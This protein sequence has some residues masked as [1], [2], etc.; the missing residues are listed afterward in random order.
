MFFLL[1]LIA[2]INCA[3]IPLFQRLDFT[4]VNSHKIYGNIYTDTVGT[5]NAGVL[6]G[7][8][9]V[10]IDPINKRYFLWY[11]LLFPTTPTPTLVQSFTWI[12][13]DA[14]YSNGSFSHPGCL[15][16]HG[17][18]W[19]T[20]VNSYNQNAYAQPD[21]TQPGYSTYAGLLKDYGSCQYWQMS[22]I[23]LKDN[24]F[25]QLTL[26]GN[27]I[28]QSPNGPFCY[29]TKNFIIFNR[30]TLEA[31]EDDDFILPSDCTANS[32]DYC[33]FNPACI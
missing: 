23:Q 32:D 9:S 19:T 33:T 11:N 16:A 17:F 7:P 1:S 30:N 10:S 18:N 13:N 12:L 24:Y 15:N 26:T 5:F 4:Q 22:I 14:T 31:V 28:L 2:L 25:S 6:S 20:F 21:S 8:A 27:I 3:P 29:N